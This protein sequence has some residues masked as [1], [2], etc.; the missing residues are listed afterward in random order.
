MERLRHHNLA[1]FKSADELFFAIHRLIA[2]RFPRSERYELSSQLRRAAL[3]V[4]ANI[5]EGFAYPTVRKRLQFLRT[6]WASLVEA[7][8]LVSVAIRLGY[9]G[10]SDQER[11]QA[12]TSAT[13]SPLAGLITSLRKA[14]RVRPAR[15]K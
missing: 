1:A 6:A 12:L 2:Q 14:N 10:R 15:T 7:D 4:P 3:S 11:I 5:V 9:L 13:G 8:Y